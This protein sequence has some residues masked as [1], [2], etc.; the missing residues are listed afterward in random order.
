MQISIFKLRFSAVSQFGV[1]RLIIHS[2]EIHLHPE[3]VSTEMMVTTAVVILNY[4]PFSF[5]GF[6]Y[7][8]FLL[9]R[10][11]AASTECENITKIF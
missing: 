5:S 9:L 1:G 8:S 10:A 6:P 11:T 4:S 7:F 2:E 3:F